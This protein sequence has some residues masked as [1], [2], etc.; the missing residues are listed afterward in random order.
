MMKEY[1]TQA[2]SMYNGA[3]QVFGLGKANEIFQEMKKDAMERFNL[4]DYEFRD[5]WNET[6]RASK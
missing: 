4:G 2:V 3:L 5:I 1:F 6:I